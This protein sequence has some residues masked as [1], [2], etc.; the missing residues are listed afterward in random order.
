MNSSKS[1]RRNLCGFFRKLRLTESDNAY[2]R[3]D[4]N[5]DRQVRKG[6]VAVYVG[7]ERKRYEIPVKYLA[8]AEFKE[9]M[10]LSQEDSFDLDVKI[11]GPITF[12]CTTE[13]FDEVL[14]LAKKH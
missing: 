3:F 8:L 6:H 1:F 12:L 14:K 13:I 11:D 10:M 7:E 9:L 5:R 2:R 4:G